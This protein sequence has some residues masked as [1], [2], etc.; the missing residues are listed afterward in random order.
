MNAF[1]I[2][3]YVFITIAVIVVIVAAIG[4]YRGKSEEADGTTPIFI[5]ILA[6]ATSGLAI[7]LIKYV[8]DTL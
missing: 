5:P 3:V 1:N 6:I 4:F 2:G 8:L 7:V